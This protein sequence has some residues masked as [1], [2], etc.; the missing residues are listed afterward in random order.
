[1]KKLTALLILIVAAGV[2]VWRFAC[3]GGM[4]ESSLRHTAEVQVSIVGAGP[5]QRGWEVT[6]RVT[7]AAS[8]SAEQVVLSVSLV[9][10]QGQALASNPL[11]SVSDLAAGEVRDATFFLLLPVVTPGIQ[12]HAQVSL[13]RWHP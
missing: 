4:S 11:A 8:R 1:M 7:N 13:V 10:T 12:P 6:C 9:D 2:W 3:T 5:T